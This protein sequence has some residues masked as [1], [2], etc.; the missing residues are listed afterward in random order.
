MRKYKAVVIDLN[1]IKK[2]LITAGDSTARYLLA[3]GNF[4][5]IERFFF[6]TVKRFD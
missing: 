5:G 4:F 1:K 6:I 2:G 3:R